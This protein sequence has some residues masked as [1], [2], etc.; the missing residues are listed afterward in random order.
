MKKYIYVLTFVVIL[1]DQFIKSIVVNNIDLGSVI[2]VIKNFFYI[3]NT[4]NT[5][6]A[7]SILNDYPIILTVI[8]ALCVILLNMYLSK[9]EDYRRIEVISYGLLMGG[10]IGNLIDR[11]ISDGV[12]DY[13]GFN[14]FNYSFPIFNIADIAIVVSI[15][16][17]MIDTIRSDLNER[18]SRKG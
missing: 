7:W 13:I 15:F 17:I 4:K 2:D 18:R 16:L 8:S 5:G 3:T 10:I 6:G 11:I 9:R 14:I 12:I 1:V